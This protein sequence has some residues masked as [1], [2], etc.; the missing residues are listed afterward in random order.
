MESNQFEIYIDYDRD[1]D[2]PERVFWALADIVSELSNFDKIVCESLAVKIESKIV[3]DKVESGS[4]RAFFTNVLEHIDDESLKKDLSLNAY[5]SISEEWNCET[6]ARKIYESVNKLMDHEDIS[7][8]YE[9][10]I[11][12]RAFPLE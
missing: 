12:S 8:L 2:N 7:D 3:L 4:V 10:G 9:K 5:R 6:A 1:A 11:M